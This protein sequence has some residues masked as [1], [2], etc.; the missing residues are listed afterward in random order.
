VAFKTYSPHLAFRLNKEGRDG[1]VGVATR[2]G[3]NGP[4]IESSQMGHGCLSLLNVV[5]YHV[6]VPATGWSLVQRSH[7][8]C[9]RVCMCLSVIV[10]PRQ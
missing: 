10:K 4:G 5:C 6:E 1:L 7:T 8:Q 9:V 3:L 2:Y